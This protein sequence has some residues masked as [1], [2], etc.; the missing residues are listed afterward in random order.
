ML[1]E[2]LLSLSQSNTQD[3]K[4]FQLFFCLKKSRAGGFAAIQSRLA[5][6]YQLQFSTHHFHSHFR[7]F[8]QRSRTCHSHSSIYPLCWKAVGFSTCNYN[9]RQKS[10]GM[11]KFTPVSPCQSFI[12]SQRFFSMKETVRSQRKHLISR[13]LSN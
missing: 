10:C 9:F 5:V 11:A 1:P 12:I 13:M 7:H 4:K 2:T 8:D 3:I 6:F